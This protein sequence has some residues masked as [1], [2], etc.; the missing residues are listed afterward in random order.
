MTTTVKIYG[1]GLSDGS[2]GH[3]KR[4]YV[5]LDIS[6]EIDETIDEEEVKDVIY[7]TLR[8]CGVRGMLRSNRVNVDKIT[9]GYQANEPEQADLFGWDFGGRKGK[10]R[11]LPKIQKTVADKYQPLKTRNP[12]TGR[13][14]NDKAR[15]F[16]NPETGQIISRREHLKLRGIVPEIPVAEQ[17]AIRRREEVEKYGGRTTEA[18]REKIREGVLGPGFRKPKG[19]SRLNPS[20]KTK[21]DY[22]EEWEK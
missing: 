11:K 9:I 13:M 15:R 2:R 20:H 17:R 8:E 7:G 4:D 14:V 22:K 18:L 21:S 19:R 5:E 10:K 12:K 1:F 6:A 3:S 16:I